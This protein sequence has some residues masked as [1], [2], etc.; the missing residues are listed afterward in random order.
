M[1]PNH[2]RLR[3]PFV[4]GLACLLLK[5]DTRKDSEIMLSDKRP[6]LSLRLLSPLIQGCSVRSPPRRLDYLGF[7]SHRK[8]CCLKRR[9]HHGTES[10]C[11]WKVPQQLH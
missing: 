8:W 4:E 2:T 3:Y 1:V 10:H 6:I 11:V 5:I 9:H 7:S